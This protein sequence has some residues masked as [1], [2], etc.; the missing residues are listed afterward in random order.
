MEA[1][2]FLI[3]HAPHGDLGT[4]LTGRGDPDLTQAGRQSAE[5]AR[6]GLPDAFAGIFT[7]PLPRARQTAAILFQD[8]PVAVEREEALNEID[9]GA[10]MGRTFA[11]LDADPRWQNWNRARSSAKAPAGESMA[12]AQ[13]RASGFV[14][15]AANRFPG[16]QIAM[17][18]HS[19][20]IRAIL[21]DFL[22]LSLDSIL[23]FE[24]APLSLSRISAGPHGGRVLSVNERMA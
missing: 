18:S 6:T 3:R 13:A 17:V 23:N 7:S 20:I 14:R 11:E 8:Q 2:I 16:E 19:D 24:V 9:F 12:A 21:C 10:W 4:T 22:R 1:E 5:T 15:D